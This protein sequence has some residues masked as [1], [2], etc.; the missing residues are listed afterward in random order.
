MLVDVNIDLEKL[1]LNTL[2]ESYVAQFA[3]D[4]S[5]LLWHL[6]APSAYD[7]NFSIKGSRGDLEKFSDVIAGEKRY[8]DAFLKYGLGDP[9]VRS[10]KMRLEKA[11]YNFEKET[12]LKWPLR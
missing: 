6:S 9:R 10:N 7:Q 4:I 11:I 1:K 5:Y 2:N 12:S 8:M 3:A